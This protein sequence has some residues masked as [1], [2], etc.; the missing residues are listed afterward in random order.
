[1]PDI[2]VNTVRRLW[3]ARLGFYSCQGQTIF[4]FVTASCAS[5]RA[6][7]VYFIYVLP[8]YVASLLFKDAFS[9]LDCISLVIGQ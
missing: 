5:L 3:A 1:M 8:S 7:A 2:S 4:I 6:Y 9:Y